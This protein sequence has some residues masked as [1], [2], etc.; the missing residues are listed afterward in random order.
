MEE[1]FLPTKILWGSTGENTLKALGAKRVLLVTDPFFESNGTAAR[2]AQQTQ[3]EAFTVF[4]QVRPDPDLTLAARGAALVRNWK[5]DTIIALGGGSAMDCA[6]AMAYFSGLTIQLVAIPTTSGSGSEVTNFAVLTHE[7][8]KYPLVDKT[9]TPAVA[10]LDSDLLK[11]LP[12]SL[13]ADTGFDVLVHSAEAYVAVKANSFTDALASA[14]FGTVLQLLERSFQGETAVRQRIHEASCMAGIAFSGAGLGVC[15]ALSHSL[16]GVFHVPHGRLNAILLPAVIRHN[17]KAHGKY[18][19][20]ASQAGLGAASETMAL[21]G[22]INGLCRLRKQLHLPG[23]LAEAG[24]DPAALAGKRP[25]ILQAALQD[26]CCA[27]NP[28]KA[29]M[30]LL[31]E[32]LQEVSGHG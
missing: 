9:L 29:D 12:P 7:G 22:L 23:S 19:A 10:I 14:S 4:S 2:I 5:P 32:I 8:V 26:P 25:E 3:A 17:R 11:S 20:L 16:G 13:I 30:P 15:H 6:K 24:I 31:N 27:T 18:A 1:F 21:R 28:Q